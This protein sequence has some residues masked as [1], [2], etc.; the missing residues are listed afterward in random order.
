[1]GA[2]G[3][4][5][6]TVGARGA[7]TLSEGEHGGVRSGAVRARHM[8]IGPVHIFDG[9]PGEAERICVDAIRTMSGLRVATANLDFLALART[10]RRLRGDLAGAHLVVADGAPVV[11]LGR[12]GGARRMRRV[13]GVDLVT[14]VLAGAADAGLRVALYGSTEEVS[15]DAA[16]EM[17]R[18]FPGVEVVCRMCPPF[19]R[20]SNDEQAAERTMLRAA[21]PQ[22]VLVALG[23]PR[24][25][26]LIAEYFDS[27]PEAVWIGIGGTLDFFAGE[28]RRAPAVLQGAGL[29]WAVRLAQEPGR[30]WRRYLLRDLPA[31]V[32]LLPSMLARR[33]KQVS[34]KRI[35][36]RT[37]VADSRKTG[38]Q[39]SINTGGRDCHHP[40][41]GA[42]ARSDV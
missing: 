8:P 30:L 40:D 9:G 2:I 38:P 10:D 11:W 20:L 32:R 37:A 26:R 23:C 21:R 4:S 41:E 31:L 16:V 42:P 18:R 33:R 6:V 3:T 35:A 19:R 39:P 34:R 28:H 25:E 12:L 5:H 17:E 1:V 15:R 36:R 27:A 24:Q 22:L 29:E 7:Q 13:A 14:G